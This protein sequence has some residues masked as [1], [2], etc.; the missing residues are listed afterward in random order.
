[1]RRKVAFGLGVMLAVLLD[2]ISKWMVFSSVPWSGRVLI[3][4]VLHLT[5]RNNA[6]GAFSLFDSYPGV[7]TAASIV[8]ILAIGYW[9]VRGWPGASRAL[10]WSQG[11]L[12]AG[13][14]GNLI[15]RV[16]SPYLVRDFFDFRPELPLI[17]H[18]AIF[19]VADICICLGV[20]MYVWA[21]LR[22]GSGAS[23][24]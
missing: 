5:P 8:A 18:W 1:M 16:M 17:K 9:C 10:L 14:T 21:E 20:G 7:L 13:A 12:L 19:N 23:E 24:K 2:Q 22:R 4:G 3:S 15:D 6:G 11:L